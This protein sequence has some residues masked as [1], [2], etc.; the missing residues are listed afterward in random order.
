MEDVGDLISAD[1][2]SLRK[3]SSPVV[4]LVNNG[5]ASASELLAG[6]MRVWHASSVCVL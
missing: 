1:I 6:A 3:I 2:E 5:T 4:L